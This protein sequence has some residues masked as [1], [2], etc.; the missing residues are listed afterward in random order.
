M[1]AEKTLTRHMALFRIILRRNNEENTYIYLTLVSRITTNTYLQVSLY[2]DSIGWRKDY[3]DWSLK[4]KGCFIYDEC[5]FLSA[6]VYLHLHLGL[7]AC[8]RYGYSFWYNSIDFQRLKRLQ[9]PMALRQPLDP[10]SPPQ[11][12]PRRGPGHRNP[13]NSLV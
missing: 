7:L 2:S 1:S 12:A 6:Q 10:P 5:N 8:F 11:P 9:I 3:S 13:S 4:Q